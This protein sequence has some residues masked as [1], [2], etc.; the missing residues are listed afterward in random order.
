LQARKS[1]IDRKKQKLIEQF[2]RDI[3]SNGDAENPSEHDNV[4]N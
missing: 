1:I 3:Y 4:D 2:Q